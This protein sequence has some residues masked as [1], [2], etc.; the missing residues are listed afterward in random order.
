MAAKTL[1]QYEAL[2]DAVDT[3]IE[4]ILT[5]AQAMSMNGRSYARAD[6]GQLRELREHYEERINS[7]NMAGVNGRRVAEF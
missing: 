6:L 7:L 5:G 2:L 1:A 3:C 4:G